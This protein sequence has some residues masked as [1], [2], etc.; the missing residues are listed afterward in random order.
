MEDSWS[1]QW[2]SAGKNDKNPKEMISRVEVLFRTALTKF[3]IYYEI[4]QSITININSSFFNS[5]DG[6]L[7]SRR[8]VDGWANNIIF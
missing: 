4:K 3:M 2:N 7:V 6:H 8:I 1:G 5:Y